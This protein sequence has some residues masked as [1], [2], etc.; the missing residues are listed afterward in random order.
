MSRREIIEK[1][2]DE[3]EEYLEW[4]GIIGYTS[5]II[6]ILVEGKKSIEYNNMKCDKGEE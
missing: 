1:Y 6:D 2:L 5:T 4:Y 3:L